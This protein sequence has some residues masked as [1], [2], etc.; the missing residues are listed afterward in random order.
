MHDTGGHLGGPGGRARRAWEGRTGGKQ[1]GQE[2]RAPALKGVTELGWEPAKEERALIL[3]MERLQS[4]CRREMVSQREARGRGQNTRG[5]QEGQGW[6][7][8]PR[9]GLGPAEIEEPRFPGPPS[10]GLRGPRGLKFQPLSKSAGSELWRKSAV[11][12]RKEVSGPGPGPQAG[13]SGEAHVGCPFYLTLFHASFFSWASPS[14]R[15]DCEGLQ[16]CSNSSREEKTV[17]I[18]LVRL[19]WKSEQVIRRQ[20]AGFSGRFL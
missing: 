13:G 1:Y 3:L 5:L 20:E 16:T 12:G 7:Q 14:S 6:V 11:S 15:E 19:K 8:G 2:T 18:D 10:S 4:V 17:E 9:E